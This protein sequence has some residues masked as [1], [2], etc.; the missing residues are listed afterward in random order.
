MFG[1]RAGRPAGAVRARSWRCGD[2]ADARRTAMASNARSRLHIAGRPRPLSA[3][4]DGLLGSLRSWMRSPGRSWPRP[5]CGR[6]RLGKLR[7]PAARWP[8]PSACRTAGERAGCAGGAAVEVGI[9]L[10][11][12]AD[13][14]RPRAAGVALSYALFTGSCCSACV[15]G[16]ALSSCGCFGTGRH[17]ADLDARRRDRRAGPG[18]RCRR[19]APARAA[20]RA[21]GRCARA[22][23]P[24]LSATPPSRSPRTSSWPVLPLL[25]AARTPPE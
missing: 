10:A 12:L 4:S 9:G 8:A 7:R 17:P 20:A 25:A 3:V 24:L 16:T 18:R 1:I 14:R 21:A 2:A 19:G 5:R 23:L 11:A 6:S 22:G 13:R 15:A